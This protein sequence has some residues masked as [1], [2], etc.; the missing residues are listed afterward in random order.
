MPGE[1]EDGFEVVVATSRLEMLG[2]SEVTADQLVKGRASAGSKKQQAET[3]IPAAVPRFPRPR[4]S[5]AEGERV[6]VAAAGPLQRAY[7][8]AGRRGRR[9]GG[10]DP[11]TGQRRRG[12]C[13]AAARVAGPGP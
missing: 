11:G 1:G 3:L 6:G 7:L 4:S 8:E 13:G 2:D 10:R 12:R 9:P 5:P